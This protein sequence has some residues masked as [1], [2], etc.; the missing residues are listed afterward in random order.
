MKPLSAAD[1]R[2][3]GPYRRYA[4]GVLRYTP[5]TVGVLVVLAL[6]LGFVSVFTSLFEEDIATVQAGDCVGQEYPVDDGRTGGAAKWLTMPC[7]LL[8]VRAAM[9]EDNRAYAYFRVLARLDA[10]TENTCAEAV[11]SWSLGDNSSTDLG[12][13]VLCLRKL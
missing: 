8:E 3:A 13:M 9:R 6:I 2:E 11:P 1:P 4:R 10:P 12:S 5:H 7:G